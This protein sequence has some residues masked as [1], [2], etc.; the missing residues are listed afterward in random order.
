MKVNKSKPELLNMKDRLPR[1]ISF[2]LH[3]KETIS[4]MFKCYTI[5]KDGNVRLTKVPLNPLSDINVWN[6]VVILELFNSDSCLL[7]RNP[8]W[9]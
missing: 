7:Y 8:N 1:N 4:V 6:F 9:K 3:L 5:C 2:P